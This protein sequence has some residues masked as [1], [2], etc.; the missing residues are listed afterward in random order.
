MESVTCQRFPLRTGGGLTLAEPVAKAV[1]SDYIEH[2]PR[3]LAVS[4][5]VELGQLFLQ[6]VGAKLR[7]QLLDAVHVEGTTVLRGIA[8]VLCQPDLNLVTCQHRRFVRR[9]VARQKSEAE[10]GLVEG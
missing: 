1:G 10:Y 4:F 7:K 2:L 6:T 3:G 8:A 9:V 5:N